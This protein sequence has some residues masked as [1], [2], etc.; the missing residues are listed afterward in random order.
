MGN[1]LNLYVPKHVLKAV[2]FELEGSIFIWKNP[3]LMSMDVMKF[4]FL[5][6]KD[7][8]KSCKSGILYEK[9]LH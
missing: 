7:S 9:I 5:C 4:G 6:E 8:V 3:E 2:Y 1:R